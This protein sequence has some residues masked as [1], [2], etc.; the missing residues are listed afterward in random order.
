M[1]QNQKKENIWK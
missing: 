1:T